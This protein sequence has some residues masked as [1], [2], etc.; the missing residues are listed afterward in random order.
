MRKH[1]ST[2][3]LILIL[4]IGLSLLLYP[5]VSDY[6]NSFHQ[7]RAIASYAEQVANLDNDTYDQLWED[8]RAYNR[9][10]LLRD[11]TFLLSEEQ[12]AEYERLL[13]VS[14]LGIMGYIEIPSI[15]VSLPIYHGTEESVLQIAVGHLD[16]TSLPVGGMS[17]HC[18]LSGH[19]GLPSAKLLTDLDR[20]VEGDVFMLRVL[21][22][23]LTYEVDQ[24]LIVEP[25]ETDALHIVEGED[26][27][28]LVTCTPY[29]I[30]THRL[31]VRGHRIENIEEAKVVRVTADAIQIEPLLV[32]PIVAIPMLLVL[33]ILLM[34]PRQQKKEHEGD[35]DEEI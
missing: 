35:A 33:L 28:T 1:L 5:S 2:F 25:H 16:W 8:A 34:L 6:W 22:E 24:V 26:Y 18:V 27:C 4:L 17:T 31:L 32:A 12:K 20:L 7:S 9:S 23:V 21:D 19:R 10:L 15:D 30:N 3:F 13:D 14:S 29:G 11:N